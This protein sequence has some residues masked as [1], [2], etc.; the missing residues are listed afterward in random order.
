MIRASTLEDLHFHDLR[1]EAISRFAESGR[2]Q[3]VEL[4]AISGHRDT[5]MLLRYVHLLSGALADK[6]DLVSGEETYVHRGRKRRKGGKALGSA[7]T[8]CPEDAHRG[9]NQVQTVALSQ[10]LQY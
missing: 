5:R 8:T 3:L 7:A 2:F 6:M 9:R 10:P 4:Q 1:H